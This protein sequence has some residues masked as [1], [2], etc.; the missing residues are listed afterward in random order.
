M[1]SEAA[2]EGSFPSCLPGT[3]GKLTNRAVSGALTISQAR[4]C[5]YPKDFLQV[6]QLLPCSKSLF[7]ALFQLQ[8]V[9]SLLRQCSVWLRLLRAH[10]SA[11]VLG[12][13]LGSVPVEV[14]VLEDS[15]VGLPTATAQEHTA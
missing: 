12:Y 13:P 5:S 3:A 8:K 1:I 15:K 7:D 10:S 2:T 6:G 11:Q 9:F 4:T 14:V